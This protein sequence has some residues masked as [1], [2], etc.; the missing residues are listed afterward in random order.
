MKGYN[1]Y[2]LI[3]IITFSTA[4]NKIKKEKVILV[5]S[6]FFNHNTSCYSNKA[7]VGKTEQEIKQWHQEYYKSMISIPARSSVL[8]KTQNL[9]GD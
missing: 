1:L 5:E 7:L 4:C 8:S 2:L 9:K 6:N 3:V